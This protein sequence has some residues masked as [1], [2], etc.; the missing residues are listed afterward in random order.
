MIEALRRIPAVQRDCIVRWELGEEYASRDPF[1]RQ[2]VTQHYG[3]YLLWNAEDL[4]RS[5]AATDKQIAAAKRRIDTLNLK[6]HEA[7]EAVDDLILGWLTDQRGELE[8]SAP[9]NSESPGSIIDRSSILA[10]RCYHYSQAADEPG[11]DGD[12]ADR[13]RLA[14]RQWADLGQALVDLLRA[15]LAGH[16]RYRLYRHLKLYGGVPAGAL[17]DSG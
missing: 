6:R 3:N 4:C 11:A 9:L 13:L 5:P 10:L 2:V 17:P 14:E 16:R 8:S 12:R 1:M 15:V 7:I